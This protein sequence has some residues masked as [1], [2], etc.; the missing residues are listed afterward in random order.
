[1]SIFE[2]CHCFIP[3][4]LGTATPT[5]CMVWLGTCS[6]DTRGPTLSKN[7]GELWSLSKLNPSICLGDLEKTIRNCYNSS[8]CPD[9]E[10]NSLSP[11]LKPQVLQLQLSCAVAFSSHQTESSKSASPSLQ[12]YCSSRK[13]IHYS[14]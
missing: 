14:T 5:M 6:N 8:L 4:S 2:L 1:M 3:S 13:A 12:M 11:A 10:S 9:R 7:E